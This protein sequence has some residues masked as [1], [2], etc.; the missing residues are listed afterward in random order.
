MF[1]TPI[2]KRV[3]SDSTDVTASSYNISSTDSTP[4]KHYHLEAVVQSLQD[5]FVKVILEYVWD[6]GVPIPWARGRKMTL[7]YIRYNNVLLI[8]FFY[9]FY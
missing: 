6:T 7:H 5:T 9:F 8:L 4:V 1:T 3:A 2:A